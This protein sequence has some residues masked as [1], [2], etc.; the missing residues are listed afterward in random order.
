MGW[1]TGIEAHG[2]SLSVIGERDC[3][4]VFLHFANRLTAYPYQKHVISVVGA[5]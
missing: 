5:Y 1:Q 2:G 4:S 3:G